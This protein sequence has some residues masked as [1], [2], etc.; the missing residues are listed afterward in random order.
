MLY[1]GDGALALLGDLRPAAFQSR[2]QLVQPVLGRFRWPSRPRRVP[3]LHQVGVLHLQPVDLSD[4]VP[5]GRRVH[6]GD[7]FLQLLQDRLPF[8]VEQFVEVFGQPAVIC[9]G[10]S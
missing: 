5:Q 9:P 10:G 2:V 1:V 4:L 8:F 6:R 7:D 3:L